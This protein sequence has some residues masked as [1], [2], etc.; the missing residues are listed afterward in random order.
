MIGY[1]SGTIQNKTKDSILLN[2]GQIG[3][4]VFLPF[5]LLNSLLEGKKYS[6]YIFTVVREQEISL[7]G[8]NSIEDRSFFELLTS[9]S[10]IGP[11]SALEFF[12]LSIS[13]IKKAILE[14]DIE[15][16]SSVKGIGKKTAERIIVELKNKVE[17]MA[18]LEINTSDKSMSNLSEDIIMALEGL[19]FEKNYVVK[20]FK[21]SENFQSTEEAVMWILQNQ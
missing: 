15:V 13:N 20:F 18:D 19:G 6:F 1:L 3:Y 7:Y 16:L 2:I 17:I 8:F 21:K 14:K 11:K 12:A 9:V 4:F 5:D 10:G